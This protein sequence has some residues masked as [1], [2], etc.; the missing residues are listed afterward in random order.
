LIGFKIV[1][2]LWGLMQL[3]REWRSVPELW[4][5]DWLDIVYRLESQFSVTLAEADF[6][7]MTSER[8]V[9]LTAG[10]LWDIVTGKI[11]A[12][13]RE[14]PQDGWDRFTELLSEA[15]TVEKHRITRQS[16]LYADLTM[17][18]GLE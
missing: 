18:Y 1:A 3:R 5:L 17:V 13:H 15:L 6:A 11:Q 14:V 16:R 8:R 12:A 10:E 9:A 2:T 7:A 4:S